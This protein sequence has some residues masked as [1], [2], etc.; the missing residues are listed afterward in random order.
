MLL[1]VSLFSVAGFFFWQWGYL[2]LLEMQI[3]L[4]ALGGISFLI[5]IFLFIKA[6]LNKRKP[7]WPVAIRLI[8]LWAFMFGLEFLVSYVRQL[9]F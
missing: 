7:Y 8:V 6:I 1:A 9:E 3:V 2:D 4:A 5:F